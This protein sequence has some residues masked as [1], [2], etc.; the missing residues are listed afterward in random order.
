MTE[1]TDGTGPVWKGSLFPI[2]VR[3][4]IACGAICPAST[5]GDLLRDHAEAAQPPRSPTPCYIGGYGGVLMESLREAVMA[6][7]AASVIRAGH[8]LRHEQ[9]AGGGRRRRPTRWPRPS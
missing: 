5:R 7:V 1:F 9:P 6:M 3:I 2:P 8:L 4:T